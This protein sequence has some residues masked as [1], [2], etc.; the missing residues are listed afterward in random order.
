MWP[1]HAAS[2]HPVGYVLATGAFFTEQNKQ[3]LDSW[4][5]DLGMLLISSMFGSPGNQTNTNMVDLLK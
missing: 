1:W 2:N 4:N 5:M 3:R